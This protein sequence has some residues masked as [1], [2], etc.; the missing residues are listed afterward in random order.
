[1]IVALFVV[2]ETFR[3][4]EWLTAIAIGVLALVV[5][6]LVIRKVVR[7]GQSSTL[8]NRNIWNV[9]TAFIGAV[10]PVVLQLLVGRCRSSRRPRTAASSPPA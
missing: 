10:E 4:P 2:A 1:V 5:I 8:L 7:A 9:Y 6:G 3:W